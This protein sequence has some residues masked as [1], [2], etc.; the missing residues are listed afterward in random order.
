MKFVDE[1]TIK[2]CAGNGGNGCVSF[3]REKYIPKG[4]PN[5]GDGGDGG[6]VYLV[7]DSSLNTLADFRVKRRFQA[8]HGKNGMGHDCTGRSGEDLKI[9][10]PL[11]TRVQDVAS[12]ESIGELLHVDQTLLVARGGFHGI[13]NA[14]FKSSVNR[15]PRRATPGSLG[16]KRELHLELRLLAHVG[17]LGLPNAGKSSF[18][19]QVSNA[20]PKVADY[21]FTTLHPNLGV[22]QV[23]LGRS[24]VIADIPGI[25]AGAAE[26]AGLGLQ[27]LKHL[28]RTKLLLHLID[29]APIDGDPATAIA[30]VETELTKYGNDLNTKERWLVLNKIDMLDQATL[31]SCRAKLIAT[32][33][34]Q[35]QIFAISALSGTGTNELVQAL[36]HRLENLELSTENNVEFPA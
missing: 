30:Q 20:H 14:R 23:G 1:A 25:I 4:G 35:G 31:A 9:S 32:T 19:R 33:N 22:V 13:G 24:F 26:G 28:T 29:M 34:W 21:P 5:G 15:A 3:R 7:A 27:F 18:I 10:V 17:L 12:S 36:M 6:N 16:E 11:G 8:Q 2:V